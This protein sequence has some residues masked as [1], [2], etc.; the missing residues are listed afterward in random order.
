MLTE[1]STNFASSVWN[2]FSVCSLLYIC[3]PIGSS[4]FQK[5]SMSAASVYI[6]ENY[7]LQPDTASSF[8]NFLDL[9]FLMEVKSDVNK[10]VSF[11]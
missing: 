9:P 10:D 1:K 3:F 2:S 5:K 11:A 4:Y 7:S 6:T 8:V